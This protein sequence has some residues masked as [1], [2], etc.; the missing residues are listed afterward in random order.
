MK[1]VK[2]Q[3]NDPFFDAINSQSLDVYQ[4][5]IVLDNSD[6]LLV[7]AGAGSGKTL[8]IIGKIKYLIEKQNIKEKEILCISFTNET[9]NNLKKKIGYDIDC[10]TF[11]KLSLEILKDFNYKFKI[12]SDNLLEY[13][14]DE[15]LEYI[16]YYDLRYLVLEY[17]KDLI[18]EKDITY[19]RFKM[20]YCNLFIGYKKMIISF[21]KKIKTNN[22]GYEDF[23]WYIKRSYKSSDHEKNKCF[24]IIVF[25]IYIWYE[26]ELSSS[27]Q[28]DFDDMINLSSKLVEESGFKRHYKYIIIDEFQ[29]TSWSRYVLIKN[30]MEKT[31]A[32]LMCVGDDYQSIYGFSGC[33]LDLFINFPK[34]FPK[35]KIMYIKNTYRNCYEVINTSCSFIK[36]N[37][38]QLKKNLNAMFTLKNPINIIYYKNS[39]YKSKFIQLLEYLYSINKKEVL[40][41]GRYN[42]DI[43]EVCDE[44]S[45]KDMNL[46]YLTVHK[47]KGLECDDV[48]IINLTNRYLG[49]PS[50]ITDDKIFELINSNN[51]NYP[52][53]EERRLFYVALTRTKRN[54]YLLVPEINYSCF[55]D[56]ISTRCNIIKL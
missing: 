38:Y 50:Q 3:I 54:I 2:D 14:T 46:K 56:E 10:F 35:A 20:K 12:V 51:E 33:T 22:H 52:Y 8:T 45:F 11:H 37:R 47:S 31:K 44:L 21:I 6:S 25:N 36:K 34:Y 16:S 27:L 9:V 26:E 15:F 41:L 18:K 17:F 30:I 53:A 29:D 49:F 4:R 28:I 43:N 23:L 32:K 5:R 24:L 13:I 55:I 42:N 7:V 19:E 40:V 39:D 1:N 48:I